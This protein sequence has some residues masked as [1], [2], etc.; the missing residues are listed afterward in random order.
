MP[1]Y[2][3][4]GVTTKGIYSFGTPL[5]NSDGRP[6]TGGLYSVATYNGETVIYANNDGS[7]AR[8]VAGPDPNTKPYTTS[9]IPSAS[10]IPS[11]WEQQPT[12]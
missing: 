3:Y 2:R 9:T 8:G 6:V 5:L 7:L 12:P 11:P 4:V 1:V 10:T